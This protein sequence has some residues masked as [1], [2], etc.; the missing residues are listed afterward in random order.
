M[1]AYNEYDCSLFDIVGIWCLYLGIPA[2]ATC[3]FVVV[4]RRD[5]MAIPLWAMW[6]L[7]LLLGIL[8]KCATPFPSCCGKGCWKKD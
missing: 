3:H 1:V 7:L 8:V 6:H 2:D 5:D 4:E